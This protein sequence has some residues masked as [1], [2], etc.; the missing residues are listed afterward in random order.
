MSV[1]MKHHRGFAFNIEPPVITKKSLGLI[2]RVRYEEGGAYATVNIDP[3]W[4]MPW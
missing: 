4:Y 2:I 3:V 1:F